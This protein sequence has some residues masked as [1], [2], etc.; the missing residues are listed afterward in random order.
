M[1]DI[2]EYDIKQDFEDCIQFFEEA[3][4][5]NGKVLCHWCVSS[6][7]IVYFFLCVSL[8]IEYYALDSL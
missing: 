1:Y 7:L 4:L 5:S 6:C 3:T 8:D 2:P